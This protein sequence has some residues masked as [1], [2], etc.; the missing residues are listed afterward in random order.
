MKQRVYALYVSAPPKRRGSKP[1][2]EMY[3]LALYTSDRVFPNGR[4][5]AQAEAYGE[6]WLAW[7]ELPGEAMTIEV[8]ID[9]DQLIA[10][11]AHEDRV[12]EEDVLP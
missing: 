8:E 9:L 3:L 6:E 2:G 10:T 5:E 1:T 4:V 11:T 12:C 7:E